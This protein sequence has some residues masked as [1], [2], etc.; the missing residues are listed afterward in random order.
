VKHHN[1]GTAWFDVDHRGH[2]VLDRLDTRTGI[3][4]LN[5]TWPTE[6]GYGRHVEDVGATN[7]VS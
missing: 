1:C 7:R 4:K 2:L 6:Q 5:L 3:V